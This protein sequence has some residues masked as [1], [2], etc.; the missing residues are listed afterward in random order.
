MTKTAHA[1]MERVQGAPKTDDE[2]F[3]LDYFDRG[4]STGKATLYQTVA[5]GPIWIPD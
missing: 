1:L 3:E 2:L 5:H 4:P